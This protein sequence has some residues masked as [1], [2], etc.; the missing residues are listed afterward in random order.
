MKRRSGCGI[1]PMADE[2]NCVD[3]AEAGGLVVSRDR[4]E[5]GQSGNAVIAVGDVVKNVCSARTLLAG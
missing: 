2:D 1:A 5:T 4:V 3:G